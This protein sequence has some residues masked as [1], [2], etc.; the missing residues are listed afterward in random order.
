MNNKQLT[1]DIFDNFNKPY[2]IPGLPQIDGKEQEYRELMSGIQG[3]AP[4]IHLAYSDLE[5]SGPIV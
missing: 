1:P 5:V 2:V 3:S 4:R